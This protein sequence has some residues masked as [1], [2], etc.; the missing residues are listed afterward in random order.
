MPS[1]NVVLALALLSLLL[2]ASSDASHPN[3]QPIEPPSFSDDVNAYADGAL[4]GHAGPEQDDDGDSISSGSDDGL[5]HDAVNGVSNVIRILQDNPIAEQI[6]EWFHESMEDLPIY[7]V[8]RIFSEYDTMEEFFDQVR[9]AMD[10]DDADDE[11]TA[12]PDV[13][14]EPDVIQSNEEVQ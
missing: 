2:L 6:S 1:S 10:S 13:V 8:I 4:G 9:A 3:T 14:T 7:S 12:F 5:P 11:Q